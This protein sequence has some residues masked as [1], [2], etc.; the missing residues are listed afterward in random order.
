MRI[1]WECVTAETPPSVVGSQRGYSNIWH[2][3]PSWLILH[4]RLQ[5]T[6]MGHDGR[7]RQTLRVGIQAE[8]GGDYHGCAESSLLHTHSQPLITLAFS[9]SCRQQT[10]S[11]LY[12]SSHRKGTSPCCCGVTTP[13]NAALLSAITQPNVRQT[14]IGTTYNNLQRLETCRN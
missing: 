2:N 12:Q 13:W 14:C 3:F 5:T 8:I 7:R 6:C 4:W 10:H 9:P 1:Y 11:F